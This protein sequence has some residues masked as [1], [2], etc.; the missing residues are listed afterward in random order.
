MTGVE[1]QPSKAGTIS[2]ATDEEHS[3][4]QKV[5][6]NYRLGKFIVRST[7]CRSIAS[8]E[9]ETSYEAVLDYGAG[10]ITGKK[11]L[12]KRPIKAAVKKL[13]TQN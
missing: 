3:V 2:T 5:E 12:V 11:K 4:S 1:L 6:W 9:E 7:E 8:R 10:I 13:D